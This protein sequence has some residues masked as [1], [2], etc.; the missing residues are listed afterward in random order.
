MNLGTQTLRRGYADA[1]ATAR[2][3]AAREAT[4]PTTDVG[5]EMKL[6]KLIYYKATYRPQA[7]K[8]AT[9]FRYDHIVI[10]VTQFPLPSSDTRTV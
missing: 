3:A 1:T 4:E 9:D 5:A 6:M 2:E 8:P 10:Q 7:T